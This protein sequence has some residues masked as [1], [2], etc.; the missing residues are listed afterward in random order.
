NYKP[1]E[2]KDE[3]SLGRQLLTRLERRVE[4]EVAE[5]LDRNSEAQ[6]LHVFNIDVQVEITNV[7]DNTKVVNLERRSYEVPELG[8][9]A[10][11][12]KTAVAD[13]VRDALAATLQ[14]H[15]L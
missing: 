9:V 4:S 7:V 12:Q 2:Q 13:A 1:P 3:G 15:P 8:A 10:A 5:A 14:K 6:Y 11:L